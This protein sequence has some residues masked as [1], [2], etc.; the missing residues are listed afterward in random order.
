MNC[1][2]TEYSTGMYGFKV[3]NE[4]NRKLCEICSK[5]T[6]KTLERGN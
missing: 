2:P 6:I 5:L 1:D 3:S 4:N